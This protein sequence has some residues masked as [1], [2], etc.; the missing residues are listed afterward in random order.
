M[1]NTKVTG[2]GSQNTSKDTSESKISSAP[3][4]VEGGWKGALYHRK[5]EEIISHF[6]P[7]KS[8]ILSVRTEPKKIRV[9]KNRA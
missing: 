7:G 6:D 1:E 9:Q 5:G 8:K 2:T 3:Y 4:D